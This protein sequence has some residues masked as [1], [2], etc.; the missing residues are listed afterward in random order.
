MALGGPAGNLALGE[1]SQSTGEVDQDSLSPRPPGVT[2]LVC[3]AL[4]LL[5]LLSP[6]TPLSVVTLLQA[7]NVPAV[8]GGRVSTGSKRRILHG[9]SVVRVQM[10]EPSL[11]FPPSCSR[12]PLTTGTGTQASSPLSRSFCSLG[13][14]WPESSPPFR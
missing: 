4:V 1:G 14:P 10:T 8:V 12:Q 3:Y 13:A 2:F 9:V 5:V 11:N 6:L 7:S